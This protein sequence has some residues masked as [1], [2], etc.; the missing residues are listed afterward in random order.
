M[1]TIPRAPRIAPILSGA[2]RAGLPFLAAA[3]LGAQTAVH[4]GFTLQSLRPTGFNPMVSGLDFLSDG[5]LVMTTWDGFGKGRSEVYLLSNVTGGDA[6]KVKVDT[7]YVGKDLNEVLGVK[8][9]DDKIYVLQKDQLSYLPDSNK[10]GKADGIVKVASGWGANNTDPKKLEFAMGIAYKDSAFYGGLATSW[11]LDGSQANERGCVIRIPIKGGSWEAYACGMRTPNGLML[12]PDDEIFTTENQGNWCPSSKLL[13]I[14]KGHFYGVHKSNPGPGP[15]DNAGETPP[16][17]WMD[18]GNI[19]ISPTQPVYMKAGPF[20]GQMIAGD[21]NMGTLQ[22]YFL[23]KVGGEWQGAIFRFSAGIEAAANRIVAGPDG[24]MY[25][26]GIGTDE[27]SGWWWNSKRYG[28]QRLAPNGKSFFDMFAVRSK[29]NNQLEIEFTA[30]AGAAAGTASNYKVQTWN[31]IPRVDYG[32]GKQTVKDLSVQTV[33]LSD[34]KKKATLTI[35]GMQAKYV[36]YL[37]LSNITGAANEQLAGTEAWYT[38]NAFGPG[39]DPQVVDVKA[40]ARASGGPRFAVRPA[41][42]GRWSV[43]V[44]EAGEHVLEILDLN[45]RALEAR[46]AAGPA[47][48]VTRG[49]Y[50]AGLFLARVRG[51][52]GAVSSRLLVAGN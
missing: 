17:I 7:F 49:G 50:A 14:M 3:Q 37:K 25:V 11:P 13:H 35:S 31:Y 39:T 42:G 22:R 16:A 8:V 34:D 12:G 32:Q 4:P 44:S 27:W 33:T 40:S 9:V 29:G 26:G 21:N 23:E 41:A 47:E 19:A 38:Q 52:S 18:H 48:I 15:F 36:V 6:S 30:P 1:K 51:P 43:S 20:K 2:L 24:A 46:R 10:D 45:G 28:L 5:R